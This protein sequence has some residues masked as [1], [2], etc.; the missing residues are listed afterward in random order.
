MY[1]TIFVVNYVF[2]GFT[3]ALCSGS[4]GGQPEMY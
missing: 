4:D 1:T 3:T 2:L